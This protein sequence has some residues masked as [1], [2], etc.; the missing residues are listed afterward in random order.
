MSIFPSTRIRK[1]VYEGAISWLIENFDLFH[2]PQ[3]D[4][5][6]PDQ[7][8]ALA[9][10]SRKAFG[11]LGLVLRIMN[12]IPD[13][14]N[15]ADFV[16]LSSQWHELVTQKNLFFNLSERI[17]NFP[18]LCITCATLCDLNRLN[19]KDRKKIQGIIGIG[20]IDRIERSAWHKL[21]L[22]YFLDACGFA[23]N[24]PSDKE[25]YSQSSL[26]KLPSLFQ[27]SA[28]DIYA[29]THLIFYFSDFGQ[30]SLKDVLGDASTELNDYISLAL[31][32]CLYERDSDLLAEILI[33]KIALGTSEACE[34][35]RMATDFLCRIQT[36]QG[37]IPDRKWLAEDAA[38]DRGEEFYAVYHPTLVTLL[39]IAC[40]FYSQQN[41]YK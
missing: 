27:A 31:K 30:R 3:E 11:E 24:L 15:H 14:R 41:G 36:P 33:N 18:F 38:L 34:T 16:Y 40:D 12:R 7:E 35:C 8:S 5:T 6:Q 29:I 21:E 37:F 20:Y 19:E 23:H 13:F 10:R 9:R 39:T 28:L 4:Q 17:Q 1:D 25:I 2:P 26:Y 32:L 22:R